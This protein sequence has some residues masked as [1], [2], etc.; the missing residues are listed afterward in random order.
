MQWYYAI[1]GQR[2]GPV[3]HT[4]LEHLV[5]AGKLSDDSLVWRQGM[6]QWQTLGE[7]KA[8]E[9]TLIAA[10]PPP[11]PVSTALT[12]GEA[13]EFAFRRTPHLH[14]E[15][16][17]VAPEVLLYAGFWRRCG[18]NLVDLVLWLFGWII[19]TNIIGMR[20]FP[21]AV[22]LNE[23]IIASGERWSY[24]MSPD[25][26]VMM[27]RFSAVMVV[28]GVVWAI[29]YDLLFLLRHSATPGKLLFGIRLVGA[30]GKPLGFARIVARCLAKGIAGIPTLGIGYLV[31]A[32]DEQKRGLHDFVCNTRVVKK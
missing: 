4:E 22:K 30:N 18:A 1:D 9:P 28:A 24:A 12:G 14:A 11:L 8:V 31:V 20:F 15:E 13:E 10:A 16:K 32:F 6:D 19:I 27:L 17:P 5:H 3:P 23:K 25:E 7:L 26:M 2:L 29:I 21:E